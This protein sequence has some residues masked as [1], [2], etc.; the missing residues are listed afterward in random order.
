MDELAEPGGCECFHH[1][2]AVPELV[3]HWLA[4]WNSIVQW[5]DIDACSA[6]LSLAAALSD[7]L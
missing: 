2:S 1:F 3:Q 7:S 4:F 6:D 5:Q